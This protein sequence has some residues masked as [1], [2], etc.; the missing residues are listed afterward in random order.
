M[1]TF[2]F[3]KVFMD[4]YKNK[5][6]V[7]FHLP[8]GQYLYCFYLLL[9]SHKAPAPSVHLDVAVVT[10]GKNYIKTVRFLTQTNRFVS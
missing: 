8:Q 10:R 3:K 6:L 4:K 5:F 7:C 1:K 2:N 9:H